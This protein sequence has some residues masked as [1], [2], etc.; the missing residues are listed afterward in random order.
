MPIYEYKCKSCGKC[1]EYMVV[2]SDDEANITCTSC[3]KKNVEKIMSSFSCIGS[4][5][6]SGLSGCAP[7]SGFS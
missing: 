1:F 4:G 3:G 5:T 2:K 7:G 6:G